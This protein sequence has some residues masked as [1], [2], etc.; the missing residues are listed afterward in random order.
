VTILLLSEI[1]PPKIG[2]SG[3]WLWEL[4]RRLDGCDVHVVT[5]KIAGAA[6]FDASSGLR[7]H[8]IP[9]R[10]FDWGFSDARSSVQY[11]RAFFKLNRLVGRIRPDVIHCGRCLP[12]GLL[13]LMV[14]GRRRTPFSCFAHGEELMLAN[15]NQELRWLTR[16]V[17]AGAKSIVANTRNTK[18]IMIDAFGAPEHRVDVLHPGV[19]ASVFKPAPPDPVIRQRLGWTDRLVVLTVGTLL[20]RKGQDMMIRA[21]PEIR[22]RCPEVLYVVVGD[23]AA[24]PMLEALVAEHRVG[25]LVQFRTITDDDELIQCYQQCDL[26]ALP[27]RQVDWDIE[28]FG[29]VLL[30]AQSCGKPVLTGSSGGTAETLEAGRTGEIVQCDAPDTLADAVSALL[31][32]PERRVTLGAQARQRILERFDWPRLARQAATLFGVPAV[33]A[34][35]PRQTG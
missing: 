5:D 16:R 25:D 20:P 11:A 19:D 26:F 30:E 28:G 31:S 24:R 21:L 22:R 4:H 33:P 1:F 32:D 6:E 12:E 17:T 7:I 35:D 3:R 27:N 23:G 10:F 14:K 18:Q 34:Q 8:R 2:G 9:L 15:T 29:I 13:A